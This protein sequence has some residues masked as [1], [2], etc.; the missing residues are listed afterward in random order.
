MRESY[1]WHANGFVTKPADFDQY[2]ETLRI[3]HQY[4]FRAAVLPPKH[5]D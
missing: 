5:D 4:W 3:L 1:R 2:V